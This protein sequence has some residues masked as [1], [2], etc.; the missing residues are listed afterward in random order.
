MFKSTNLI[1]IIR[2]GV[3]LALLTPLVYIPQTIFGATF[4]KMIYF[5]IVVELILPFYLY[6]I[7]FYKDLRPKIGGLTKVILLFFAALFLS[8]LLGA[9]WHK[10]FWG[11]EERMRGL[12]GLLHF[13]A[14]YF[15][16]ITVFKT[17]DDRRKLLLFVI[18]FGIITAAYGV[19]ERINPALSIDKVSIKSASGHRVMSTTGNSIFLAGYLIFVCFL[20]LH[21]Y[22][23]YK[24]YGRWIGLGGFFLSALV[25]FFTGT[26]G[27][28]LGFLG[29][30]A[31]MLILLF[32]NATKK[33]KIIIAISAS[34]F[35][36]LLLLVFVADIKVLMKNRY[37][38]FS[39]LADISLKNSGGSGYSRF[40]LWQS[41]LKAFKER[42]VLGWGAENFDYGFD[43]YYNPQF[44][45]GGIN[46]TWSDRAHNWFLDFLVMGGVPGLIAYSAIFVYLGIALAK[47][48]NRKKDNFVFGALFSAFLIHSFF[49][50]DDPSTNLMLFVALA[51]CFLIFEEEKRITN[52]PPATPERSDD[53]RGESRITNRRSV[54]SFFCLFV[55]SLLL[56][57]FYN[58]RPLYAGIDFISFR[59][60]QS[61]EQ[62]KILAEKFLSSASPYG[63]YFRFRF[64]TE[65][66]L[67]AG[68]ISDENYVNWALDRAAE[69][70]ESVLLRH[71]GDYSYFH[72]LGNIYLRKGSLFKDAK[73]FDAAIGIYKK[74]L[75]ISSGRQATIFQLSTAYLFRGRSPEAVK[76]LK[77]A[78][79]SDEGVG[80]SH[81]RLG[82]ALLADGKKEE[83]YQ[84]F[85]NSIGRG[86]F[87]TIEIEQKQAI[88]LCVR[89][90][91]YDCAADAYKI[92][93]DRNPQDAD[94]Y[95]QLAAAYAAAGKYGEA[96][97]AVMKAVE[98]NPSL[99]AEAKVFLR[100]IGY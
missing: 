30:S 96:K 36:L 8:S 78:V 56:I 61:P 53:G 66:F 91:D 3:Y 57:Y 63:D 44:Y 83:A 4:G 38:D 90:E 94:L 11:N 6:L 15:Y 17:S 87:D 9:D 75:E 51:V 80:Q 40:L 60:E 95:A 26:R 70:M 100:Q 28:F 59:R 16:I 24:G 62:K 67:D 48:A 46:E 76:I 64:A 45:R 13:L 54:F 79:S 35:V 25:I 65:A 86:F 31:V 77:Q 41:A 10:S 5:Q 20:S 68:R 14:L 92:L 99:E 7:L 71:P 73:S 49:A 74:A 72:T 58:L 82:V 97:N 50:V 27:A 34:A 22:L 47:K 1:K 84:S 29:G 88:A 55:S 21:Y 12:F 19:A 93:V 42:P 33:K 85:K 2:F 39:R 43:K 98:L 69:E 37:W 18:I 23:K 89:F 32:F 52:Y 81:W